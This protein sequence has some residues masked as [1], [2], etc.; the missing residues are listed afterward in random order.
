MWSE[1]PAHSLA[2]Y[3]AAGGPPASSGLSFPICRMG[4]LDWMFLRPMQAL[5]LVGCLLLEVDVCLFC[6]PALGWHCR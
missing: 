6:C 1:A 4:V 2:C 3:Q 5:L